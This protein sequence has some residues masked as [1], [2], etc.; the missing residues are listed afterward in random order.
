MIK[1]FIGVLLTSYSLMFWI[2][3]LN[4]IMIYDLIHYLLYCF[5]HYETLIIFFGIYLILKS[6][7]KKTTML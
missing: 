4:Q 5:S 1:I 2:I 7:L 3:H 6:L